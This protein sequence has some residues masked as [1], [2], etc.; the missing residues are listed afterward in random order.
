ML[1]PK[2]HVSPGGQIHLVST[3]SL[4]IH[5]EAFALEVGPS[6]LAQKLLSNCEK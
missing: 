5:F 3:H 6:W 1:I 4:G 2:T